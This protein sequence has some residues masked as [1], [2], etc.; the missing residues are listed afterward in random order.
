MYILIQEGEVVVKIFIWT[1]LGTGLF[2][3]LLAVSMILFL[4]W[5]AVFSNWLDRR[6]E[7]R[8]LEMRT[9]YA[10]HGRFF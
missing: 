6:E 9:Y 2:L 3:L 4:F 5:F 7:K 1:I 8:E 10:E